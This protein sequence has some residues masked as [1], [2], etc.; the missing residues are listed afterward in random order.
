MKSEELPLS[1]SRDGSSGGTRFSTRATALLRRRAF[2]C[3]VAFSRSVA[4][5][6][7][8]AVDQIGVVLTALTLDNE[9]IRLPSP[10]VAFR[11]NGNHFY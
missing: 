3:D 7:V 1:R 11:T 2:D 6:L 10:F 9:T 5:L 8:V 4:F